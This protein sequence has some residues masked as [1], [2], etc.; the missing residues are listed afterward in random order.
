M[1]KVFVNGY[2]S[3]GSRITAFIKDDPEINLI[4]VGKYSPDD[5]IRAALSR[6]V[7]VYVPE[8]RL[9]EFKDFPVSGTI[10]SALDDCDMVIDAAPAGYGYKNKKNLY[11]PKNIPAIYQGGETVGEGRR[12]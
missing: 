12:L 9:G 1:K 2:G 7:D 10:E 5:S 4:G 3:I 6:G 8:Q 11:E